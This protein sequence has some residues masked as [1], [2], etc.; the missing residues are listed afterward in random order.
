MMMPGETEVVKALR[1]EVIRLQAVQDAA[2]NYI[3]A[4]EHNRSPGVA[5]LKLREL[6]ENVAREAAEPAGKGE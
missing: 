6:L 5:L 3:H 2:W 4:C 1:A